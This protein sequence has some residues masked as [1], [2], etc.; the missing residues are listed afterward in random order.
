MAKDYYKILGITDDEKALKGA[1][2]E[3]VIKKKYR[4][5]AKKYHPD[6]NPNNKEAEEKFKDAA[7][8]YSVLSDEK[9]RAEYDSP[10]IDG[11]EDIMDKF[12]RDFGFRSP[13]GSSPFSNA[14]TVISGGNIRITLT[15][16][17]EEILSGCKKK[18]RYKRLEPCDGCGGTGKTDKSHDEKCPVCGGTGRIFRREGLIQ[19]MMMC[20]NCGG[21]GTIMKD[22]CQK[23]GGRGVV[24]KYNEVEVEIPKGVEDGMQL[25]MNGGGHAP[26]RMSG[27]YG[28][29][30]IA[31]RE[32]KNDKFRREGD[33][34]YV[35]VDVD[36]P[37]ALLGGTATISTLNGKKLSIKIKPGTEDG[38]ISR[39]KGYGMPLFGGNGN[40]Y[41]DMYGIMKIKVPNELN[42][43]ERALIE[44]LKEKEHFK[45]KN[46]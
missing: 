28:D 30:I 22:P 35:N 5:I 44:Q 16:T 46:D 36:I 15:V 18:L 26:D 14:N 4:E 33:D 43:D 3:K 2:F 11:G 21:S 41:G 19:M 9:K 38:N 12:M 25:V 20:H 27:N 24:E 1:D 13:F 10:S 7:E 23:C 45:N 39:F 42:E 37:T 34:L 31:I 6:V 40:K 29:L 8:A 32:A 17:L